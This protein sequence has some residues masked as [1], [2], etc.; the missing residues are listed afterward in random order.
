MNTDD[1]IISFVSGLLLSGFPFAVGW[2]IVSIVILSSYGMFFRRPRPHVGN[3]VF[4]RVEPS[5][6]H[7]YSST[8]VICIFMIIWIP[9]P[10]FHSIPNCGFAG[11]R[12][13]VSYLESCRTISN[14]F[15]MEAS[16]GL[17]ESIPNMTSKGSCKRTASAGA[18]PHYTSTGINPIWGNSGKP[19]K[20]FTSYI[21]KCSAPLDWLAR[22]YT[23]CLVLAHGIYGL[24]SSEGH[25]ATTDGLCAFNISQSGGLSI[26]G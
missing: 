1:Y 22:R 11:F 18:F 5:I 17:G 19:S 13:P 20:F 4:K 15:T 23:F 3:E 8:P 14:N 25:S 6:A 16:T 7:G 9:A 2:F 12:H 26:W 24:S 10:L 21:F